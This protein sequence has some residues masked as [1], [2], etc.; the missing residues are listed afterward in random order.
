[1]NGFATTGGDM[2]CFQIT[3]GSFGL[4]LS[5]TLAREVP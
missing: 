3:L 2:A 5:T 1:M 4:L